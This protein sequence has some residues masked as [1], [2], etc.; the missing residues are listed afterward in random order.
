MNEANEANK[1]SDTSGRDKISTLIK[2]VHELRLATTKEKFIIEL[3][4]KIQQLSHKLDTQHV[5]DLL[6]QNRYMSLAI[7]FE[8]IAD[9]A[10]KLKDFA[11]QLSMLEEDKNGLTSTSDSDKPAARS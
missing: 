10:L 5:S 4:H 1:T 8:I 11:L 9:I 3:S 6:A 2:G 7:H